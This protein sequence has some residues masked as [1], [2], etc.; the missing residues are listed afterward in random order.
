MCE[1]G[2]TSGNQSYMLPGPKRSVYLLTFQPACTDCDGPTAVIVQRYPNRKEVE[3]L[4]GDMP[5]ELP[6]MEVYNWLETTVITGK[7]KGEFIRDCRN[8]LIGIDPMDM[9]DEESG[10]WDDAAADEILDEMYGDTT[11][12]PHLPRPETTAENPT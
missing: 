5:P 11:T 12:T 6:M 9:A 8:M 1:C 7:T 10:T 3:S 4:M 2:C